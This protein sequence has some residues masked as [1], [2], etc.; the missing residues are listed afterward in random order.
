MLRL[1]KITTAAAATIT[2]KQQNYRNRRNSGQNSNNGV[3]AIKP[4]CLFLKKC[5]YSMP[6]I[7]P[8]AIARQGKRNCTQTQNEISIC[9]SFVRIELG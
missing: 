3:N 1:I 5:I 8:G 6:E 2:E 7:V 9:G 4:L